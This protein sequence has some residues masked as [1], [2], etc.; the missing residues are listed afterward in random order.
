MRNKKSKVSLL[1]FKHFK[2]SVI[3]MTHFS[4]ILGLTK[5]YVTLSLLKFNIILSKFYM[6][7]VKKSNLLQNS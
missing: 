1:V 6:Y 4:F 2:L 7:I 5:L 3:P